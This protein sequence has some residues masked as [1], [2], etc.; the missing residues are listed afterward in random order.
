MQQIQHSADTPR[1][2]VDVDERVAPRF[3]LMIRTGKL[4]VEDRQYLCL[5]RDV[6]ATGASVRTFHP[7][8]QGR[9]YAIEFETGDRVAADLVWND[10]QVAGFHFHTPINVDDLMMG[11]IRYPKRDLRFEIALPVEI[12]TRNGVLP[13]TISNLSRQGGRIECDSGLALD[14][15]VRIEGAGMPEI[16]ARVRWRDDGSYGLVFDT[17]FTLDQLARVLSHLHM[18]VA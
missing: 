11:S 6:S 9:R 8:V 10:G 12:H 14:Q 15:L 16:E 1:L 3:T 4:I 5:L 2:S 17:T 13:A 7:L 18:R